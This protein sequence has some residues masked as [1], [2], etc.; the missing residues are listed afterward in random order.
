M[1]LEH[2]RTVTLSHRG[3]TIGNI[4]IYD[5]R[6]II[7]Y[8]TRRR[9]GTLLANLE[10]NHRHVAFGIRLHQKRKYSAGA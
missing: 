8:K 7:G 5:E 6:D 9:I 1:F 4:P 3:G 2:E 10:P